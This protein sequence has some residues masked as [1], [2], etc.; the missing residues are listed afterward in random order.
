M[1]SYFPVSRNHAALSWA[2]L[3]PSAEEKHNSHRTAP[4]RTLP[5]S[6]QRAEVPVLAPTSAPL[7][8]LAVQEM[9]FYTLGF[10]VISPAPAG[11]RLRMGSSRQSRHKPGC[12]NITLQHRFALPAPEQQCW[13]C[14]GVP[15]QSAA[16]S[17]PSS[18]HLG[19]RGESSSLEGVILQEGPNSVC[20][21]PQELQVQAGWAALQAGTRSSGGGELHKTAF[22]S[23]SG[24]ARTQ[25]RD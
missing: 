19:K 5:L 22:K 9:Y 6:A 1:A 12:T 21:I 17:T 18:A 8:R 7:R 23:I 24:I 4:H 3:S 13:P 2:E 15:G 20:T 16:I 11:C 14:T 25:T 10:H